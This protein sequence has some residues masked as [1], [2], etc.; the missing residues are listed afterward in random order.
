MEFSPNCQTT[1]MGIMPHTDVDRALALASSLDIPYWPQL[2][3]VSYY[4]DMYAQTSEGFPGVRVDAQ[5]Q[6]VTFDSGRFDEEIAGYS[7]KMGDPAYFLLS[8]AYSSVYH[9]FLALD[10]RA[11]AA[12]RG[13]VTGP[14]SFGF[15][16]VDEAQKP[17]IYN[18]SVKTLLFD[19]VQKKLNAQRRQLLKLNPNAFVWAD[20]PGLGWVFSG[21]SGYNDIQA[22]SDYRA[23]FAGIEGIKALHLCANVNLPFLLEL[24]IE[25]ISFDAY[26]IE[27][28]P[29]AYAGSVAQFL[30]SGGVMAWGVVPTD[31]TNLERETVAS[32]FDLLTGYWQVIARESGIETRQIAAQSLLAPARCCLKNIGQAGSVEDAPHAAGCLVSPVEERLVET[33]FGVLKELS[34]ALR[35]SFHV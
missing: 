17:V 34:G 1:A 31:S 6:K 24:G 33:A 11:K 10:L 8:E 25:M 32:L 12:V 13:Q 9:R 18:E 7:E 2:P 21:M 27:S 23:F 29:K 35:Q 16:V 4:E 20:E 14:V 26:Q 22:A 30:R 19:F 5:G 3:H 15:R 28:M